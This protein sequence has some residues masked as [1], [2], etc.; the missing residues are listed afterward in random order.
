MLTFT[1]ALKV[2]LRCLRQ[3]HIEEALP[4]RFRVSQP[5]IS[6]II[7]TVEKALMSVLNPAVPTI[8][9]A[10]LNTSGIVIINGILVSPTTGTPQS[11][12]YILANTTEPGFN[13]WAVCALNEVLMIID[14]VPEVHQD[15]FAYQY[16]KL[17]RFLKTR[18]TYWWIE[19]YLGLD[20]LFPTKGSLGGKVTDGQTS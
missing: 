19:H 13:P 4:E 17:D 14:P 1:Q 10:L 15:A 3:I 20:L 16:H 18:K 5:V 9:E 2:T 7:T 6:R 12:A 11:Y 8:S